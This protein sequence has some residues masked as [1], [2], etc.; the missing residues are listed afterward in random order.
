MKLAENLPHRHEEAL[1]GFCVSLLNKQTNPGPA[2]QDCPSMCSA[3]EST[4]KKKMGILL[5][6]KPTKKDILDWI[7]QLTNIYPKNNPKTDDVFSEE[8]MMFWEE[9]GYVILKNA[10][11]KQ[12]CQQACDT[13][14]Q[15]LG[16]SI[17]DKN[18]WYTPLT[19][20]KK[21][22]ALL[23]QHHAINKTRESAKIRRAFEQLYNTKDIYKKASRIG[24]N[25][26]ENRALNTDSH[27]L[28]WDLSLTLPMPYMLQG[29]LYLNDVSTNGGAF[30]C[31]PG[32]HLQ[33]DCWLNNI[34]VGVD[35][36]E[37]AL[38]TLETVSV[39]GNAGDLI[40]WNMALPYSESANLGTYP[41]LTQYF[42]F[43]PLPSPL[44]K[45]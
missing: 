35:V 27:L 8:E 13:I 22:R 20:K 45:F 42:A 12:D 9:N 23:T 44:L 43:A 33:I 21:I 4:L 18:S 34:P 3:G 5:T 41:N 6:Y 38:S 26:P 40:I 1:L 2:W 19:D 36:N 15:L 7:N 32:F 29:L 31:V 17:H 24:F 11:N 25:P 30:K 14:Y 39:P 37:F 28:H 10:I 16:A